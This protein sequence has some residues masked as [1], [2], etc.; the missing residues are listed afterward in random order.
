MAIPPAPEVTRA[1]GKEIK[2]KM[3]TKGGVPS[4]GHAIYCERCGRPAAR[5]DIFAGV[6][7]YVHFAKDG[8]RW[9][10]VRHTAVRTGW[11]EAAGKDGKGVHAV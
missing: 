10:M 3:V 1:A 4:G 2:M 11:A 7:Q 9:R 6:I 8:G 5:I